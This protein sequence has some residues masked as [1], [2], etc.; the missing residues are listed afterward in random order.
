MIKFR[1]MM[2]SVAGALGPLNLEMMKASIPNNVWILGVD[3]RHDYNAEYLADKFEIVPKGND[4]EYLKRI[5]YLIKKFNINLVIPCSDEE[6]LA[7]SKNRNRIEDLGTKIA[8]ASKKSIKIMSNKLLT[9]NFLENKNVS[10]PKYKIA[11][12]LK[13]LDN[14]VS[15]FYKEYE[16]FVIKDPI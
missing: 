2:T 3:A 14:Y 4:P 11:K 13:E 10:V 8:C 1:L 16:S 5:C 6:A 7:L 12:N 9:Y 15:D